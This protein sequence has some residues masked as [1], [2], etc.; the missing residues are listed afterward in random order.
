MTAAP[1]WRRRPGLAAL[2]LP[3]LAAA[4]LAYAVGVTSPILTLERFVIARHSYSILGGLAELW[5]GGHWPVLLVIATFS[6]VLPLAKILLLAGAW[7]AP[8]PERSG[9]LRWLEGLGRWAMLDVFVVA[10]LVASVQLG[11]LAEVELRAGLYAFAACVLLSMAAA[12]IT[13]ALAQRG[14]GA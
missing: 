4:L 8:A 5:R 10:V 7:V 9:A 13:G 2:V 6:L 3:L 12:R 1:L 11:V 14:P